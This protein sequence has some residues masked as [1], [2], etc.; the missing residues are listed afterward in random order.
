MPAQR[1]HDWPP[2]DAPAQ[3]THVADDFGAGFATHAVDQHFDSVA[4]D[5]LA[6]AVDALFE[7]R[8]RHDR[9]GT[10]E[11]RVHQVELACRQVDGR[12]FVHEL[13]RREVEL[14][15]RG[16]DGRLRMTA[17]ASNDRPHAREQLA[18]L[19]RLDEIIVGTEIE[20]RHAIVESVT[21]GEH[22]HRRAIALLS[23]SPQHFQS[24]AARQAEIEQH[25]CV[26]ALRERTLCQHA[27]AHPI[28]RQTRLGQRLSQA[29]TDHVV[30]FDE[31]DTHECEHVPRAHACC[32]ARSLSLG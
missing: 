22:E 12:T 24:R 14:C 32:Q 20:P 27:V 29:V 2:R 4:G 25:S 11:Q 5:F 28:D 13:S 21:R 9:A 8:A 1:R 17:G 6:P 26:A 31:Q 7:L 19:E 18:K 3:A 30:V 10:F 15:L 23:R 16:A